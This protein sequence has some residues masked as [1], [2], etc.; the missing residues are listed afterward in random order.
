MR[1]RVCATA[2][3]WGGDVSNALESGVHHVDIASEWSDDALVDDGKEVG[4]IIADEVVTFG[5]EHS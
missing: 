2:C 5:R 1:P 4:D 3:T